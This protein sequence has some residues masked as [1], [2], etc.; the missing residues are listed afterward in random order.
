MAPVSLRKRRYRLWLARDADG[1]PLGYVV[2]RPMLPGRSRMM[3][4][5][6]AA[7][8][9]DLVALDDDPA[10]L[11]AL[12]GKAVRTAAALEARIVLMTTTSSAHAR[13]LAGFLSPAT[14][15]VGRLLAR[16]ARSSC[17]GPKGSPPSCRPIT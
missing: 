14:P 17:G 7:M 10:L 11:R 8:I 9:T 16:R 15:L 3:D 12:V 2:V 1:R 6:K 4:R 5:L 13:A